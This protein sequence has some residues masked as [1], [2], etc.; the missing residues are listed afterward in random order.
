M[1]KGIPEHSGIPSLFCYAV[2][3]RGTFQ[4]LP[5]TDARLNGSNRLDFS[6]DISG[7]TLLPDSNFSAVDILP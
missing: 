5:Q 2:F 7:D 4:I 1:K 3:I 6:P